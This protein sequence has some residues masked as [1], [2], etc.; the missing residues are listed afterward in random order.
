MQTRPRDRRPFWMGARTASSMAVLV[1]M[2]AACAGGQDR[3]PVR[4]EEVLQLFAGIEL[5][6]PRSRVESAL[7]RPLLEM[8][9]SVDQGPVEH[10]LLAWYLESPPLPPAMSPYMPGSIEVVYV[11]DRVVEKRLSPPIRR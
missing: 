4:D 2:A 8:Q 6:S 7:G 5:G 3:Q 10:R 9:E 1:F 11:R